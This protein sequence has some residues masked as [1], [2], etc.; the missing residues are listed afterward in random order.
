LEPKLKLFLASNNLTALPEELFHLDRLTALSLRGNTLQELPPGIGNLRNLKELNISLNLLK[1]LP[2]EILDLFSNT[3][4]IQNIQIHPNPFYQ[5]QF[6]QDE[7]FLEGEPEGARFKIGLG[8]P[9]RPRG[10]R[11]A[12]CSVLPDAQRSWHPQWKASFQARTDVRYFDSYGGLV[13]GP[14]FPKQNN[15]DAQNYHNFIPT[16]NLKLAPVPPAPRGSLLSRAP[17]LV[18]VALKACVRTPQFPLLA[19]LLPEESPPYL[20]DLLTEAA[21]QKESGSGKCTI[22]KRSFIIQR[23]EWIEWWEIAK[24]TEKKGM[25]SAA[26]PLRQMEN[27]RDV[28]ESMVPLIRRGCSWLCVP[29]KVEVME[30]ADGINIDE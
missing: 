2:F 25:A 9:T 11:G 19:S 3:G 6:S 13:K 18:E 1:Y 27:E 12:I 21:A 30:E 10:R 4:R 24:V 22:C 29:E 14:T 7:E 15:D 28:L 17:S 26:S 23:T 8:S 20:L 5:P 16:T